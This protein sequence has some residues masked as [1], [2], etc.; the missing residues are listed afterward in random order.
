MWGAAAAAPSVGSEKVHS[1]QLIFTALLT[2]G[3]AMGLGG[4]GQG[5]KDVAGPPGRPGPKG[6]P[7]VAGPPGPVGRTTDTFS[8]G[9]ELPCRRGLAAPM[10]DM[11]SGA[12]TQT[13]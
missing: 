3:L 9:S 11:Q 10:Q 13:R 12:R 2:P 1:P 8:R 5:S 6:D 7:G 4:C